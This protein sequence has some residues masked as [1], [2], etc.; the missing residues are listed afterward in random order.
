MRNVTRPLCIYI[1]IMVSSL[2]TLSGH[3]IYADS[4]EM[5]SPRK[6]KNVKDE[7][8]GKVQGKTGLGKRPCSTCTADTVGTVRTVG[9]PCIF[10]RFNDFLAASCSRCWVSLWATNLFFRSWPFNPAPLYCPY[11]TLCS[12]ALDTLVKRLFL[13]NLCALAWKILVW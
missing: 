6:Y 3:S 10:R 7:I 9:R 11:P 13:F 2:Y 5:H 12:H 1:Y 8:E 4:E